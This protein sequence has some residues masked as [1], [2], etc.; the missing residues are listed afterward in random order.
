MGATLEMAQKAGGNLVIREL[1]GEHSFSYSDTEL[2]RIFDFLDRSIRNPI[3]SKIFWETDGSDFGKCH[4]FNIESIANEPNQPWHIDHNCILVS[5]QVSIGFFPEKSESG[6][7]VGKVMDDSYAN[8]IGLKTCDIVISA[9]GDKIH[10]MEDL[11]KA[12]AKVSRGDDFPIVVLRA[13]S[14]VLL[15]GTL[16]PAELYYLFKR[17]LPSAAARVTL[18]GNRVMVDA[19]RVG[20]IKLSFSP[21]LVRLQD[22]LVVLINDKTVY[23]KKVQPNLEF[24]IRNFLSNRDRKRI[25]V[26]E[27]EIASAR[28]K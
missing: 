10:S 14:T 17:E 2:P 13:S 8:T 22:P 5:D 11:D 1:E 21:E 7:K 9:G 23:S 18:A 6:V 25:E 24:M 15:K 27:V 16:P 4:W 19:S 28:E 26:A 12:K 20:K 3:P